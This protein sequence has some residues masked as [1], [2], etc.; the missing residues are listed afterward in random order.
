MK[1]EKI[2]GFHSGRTDLPIAQRHKLID[3]GTV[4]LF[5]ATHAWGYPAMASPVPAGG[6]LINY[7][8]GGAPI[9]NG[10]NDRLWSAS[11]GVNIPSGS[12]TASL[13][14][15]A[16]WQMPANM[17]HYAIGF[18]AKISTGGIGG[19]D[20]AQVMGLRSATG[21]QWGLHLKYSNNA[22]TGV[23][24]LTFNGSEFNMTNV[25]PTDGSMHHY[26]IEFIANGVTYG[27]KFWIDGTLAYTSNEQSYSGSIL[28]PGATPAIGYFYNVASSTM[29]AGFSIPWIWMQNLA[30]PGS[31]TLA[32]MITQDRAINGG[33]FS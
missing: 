4:G 32:Q 10:P 31:K 24:V 25:L 23:A 20:N 19:A 3:S 2:P 29:T 30:A 22:Y 8:R 1:F 13:A 11:S 21:R 16:S 26:A 33:N 7:V 17:S 14:L 27:V 18:F 5:R 28:Q 6:N 9:V 12:K 15:P